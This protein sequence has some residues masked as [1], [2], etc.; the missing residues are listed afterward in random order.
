MQ[1]QL[2]NMPTIPCAAG[3]GCSLSGNEQLRYMSLSFVQPQSSGA[4]P[5]ALNP[6]GIDPLVSSSGSTIVSLADTAFCTN[7]NCTTPTSCAPN[8]PCYVTLVVGVGPSVR[9]LAGNCW[10]KGVG[11]APSV[12]GACPVLQGNG[13]TV[14][15]L[16]QFLA[17]GGSCPA[18]DTCFSTSQ[19]LQ[20]VLRE[21]LPN[22]ANFGCSGQSVPF[23]TAEYTNG[24]SGP[25]G[26]MGPFVPQVKYPAVASLPATAATPTLPSKSACGVLPSTPPMLTPSTALS[27]PGNIVQWPTFWPQS[28]LSPQG[29][30]C[31]QGSQPTSPIINFAASLLGTE[32]WTTCAT[33]S[34][35]CN[36]VYA[37]QAQTD[38]FLTATVPPLPVTIV[39]S[40]FGYLPEV[41]PYAVQSSQYLE[42]HDDMNG[43]G[44]WDTGTGSDDAAC[45]IYIANWT[46]T[47]ISVVANLPLGSFNQYLKGQILS[48]LSDASPLT[49]FP[50]IYNVQ[51]CP[52]ANGDKLTFYVTN[53]QTSGSAS[54]LRV[55][56]G[57]PGVCN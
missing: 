48:P 21:T 35:A 57:T 27:L 46:D 24:G 53:P 14:L 34:A 31:G 9:G 11:S 22:M 55:C 13:Y 49:L 36:Y 28:P 29:L 42:I 26:L 15:D 43:G 25:A 6:D 56:V 37:I 8:T 47:S 54:P 50:N 38:A 5:L 10:T 18:G 41:L 7:A 51:S 3:G 1:F 20:L 40:G 23:N 16:S 33:P 4:Q 52:I 2:P 32:D 12:G 45:Q 19:N 30:Y 44:S 39:G 17:P